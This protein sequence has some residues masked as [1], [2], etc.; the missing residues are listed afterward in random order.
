MR[1]DNAEIAAYVALAKRPSADV[2]FTVA[3]KA[4]T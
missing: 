4:S 1:R 2:Q 3:M